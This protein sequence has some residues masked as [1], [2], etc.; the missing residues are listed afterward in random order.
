MLE[1]IFTLQLIVLSSID[2][3]KAK[4]AFLAQDIVCYMTKPC[5]N[6]DLQDAI[7]AAAARY[8]AKQLQKI[9]AEAGHVSQAD[10]A[11][12]PEKKTA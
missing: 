1:V 5:R 9:A 3:P 4:E 7:Y 11:S 12:T 10:R 6:T 2:A 8:K